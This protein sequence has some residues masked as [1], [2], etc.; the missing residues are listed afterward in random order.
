GARR[1][2]R[3][4]KPTVHEE[5]TVRHSIPCRLIAN[6]RLQHGGRYDEG[7]TRTLQSGAAPK[8]SK[9]AIARSPCA[10]SGRT[11]AVPGSPGDGGDVESRNSRASRRAVC[12]RS[13]VRLQI[14][15]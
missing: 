10:G 15:E 8:T 11:R 2:A 14:L 13:R 9:N 12:H 5:L 1:F 6:L 4:A 3:R 7:I